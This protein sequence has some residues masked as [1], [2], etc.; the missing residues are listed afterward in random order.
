MVVL[1]KIVDSTNICTFIV[2]LY[3]DKKHLTTVYI[4]NHLIYNI[5][6]SKNL[7]Q[8]SLADSHIGFF[9]KYLLHST[10][11]YF[12]KE[13]WF[14]F[15][16]LKGLLSK[17]VKLITFLQIQLSLLDFF[18][19]STVTAYCTASENKFTYLAKFERLLLTN[20]EFNTLS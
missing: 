16:R 14:N 15:S 2:K 9:F 13:N 3:P 11:G 8:T 20:G 19:I 6:F 18:K 4:I 12:L 7:V 1:T 5:N 10:T 17:M